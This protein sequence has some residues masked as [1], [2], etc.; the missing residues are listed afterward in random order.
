MA[1]FHVRETFAIPDKPTFVLA[2]FVIEG[3]VVAGMAVG[4]PFNATAKMTANIDRIEFIRRPDG[5]VVCLCFDCS[6]RDELT[7]WEALKIKNR[8]IEITP[9]A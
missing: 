6:V 7:L 3:E 5:D 8:S 2:G 4:V 1:R 9:A